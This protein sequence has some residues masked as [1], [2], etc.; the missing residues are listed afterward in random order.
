MNNKR[1]KSV[2]RRPVQSSM[3]DVHDRCPSAIA[4]WAA[5][6]DMADALDTQ[7]LT[8]TRQQ[9]SNLCGV[10]DLD[11][12]SK[13]L[14]VLHEVKWICKETM[15]VTDNGKITAK[16]LRITIT[17]KQVTP[18]EI[19]ES[20]YSSPNTRSDPALPKPESTTDGTPTQSGIATPD[21]TQH[22]SSFGRPAN[23]ASPAAAVGGEVPPSLS[24]PGNQSTENVN[25][26]TAGTPIGALLMDRVGPWAP[27]EQRAIWERFQRA[28]AVREPEEYTAAFHAVLRLLDV[29]DADSEAHR[30]LIELADGPGWATHINLLNTAASLSQVVV[31]HEAEDGNGIASSTKSTSVEACQNLQADRSSSLCSIVENMSETDA[32]SPAMGWAPAFEFET[33]PRPNP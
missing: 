33:S 4:V 1:Q 22:E 12:I 13:A 14:R 31:D 26:P 24:E 16:V 7:C 21:S 18:K 6:C 28:A 23:A 30:G 15:P 2:K 29:D 20:R 25:T 11:T 9:L 27:D 3:R 17:R 32:L 8:P 10:R 19:H 5:L